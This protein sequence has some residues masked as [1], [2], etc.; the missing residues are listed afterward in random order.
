M[1]I[2]AS[3]PLSAGAAS[4]ARGRVGVPS[5]TARLWRPRIRPAIRQAHLWLGLGLGGLFALISLTGSALVFYVEIDRVL[6]PGIEQTIAS[7]APDWSSPVWDRALKTARARW[8][9]P[10]GRWSFEVTGEAGSIPARYYPSA[11]TSHHAVREMVWFSSDGAKVLR[12]EPWGSYLMSWLY[13]LHMHLLAGEVG[14]QVV[15]WSGVAALALMI[16]GLVVWWPRG[17]LRKA[18]AFKR[19]AAP[20]RRL[21]D[22][23]KLS[24]LWSFAFLIIL[25]GTGT[26]LA[27]PSVKTA[28]IGSMIAVPDTVPDPR[29][30]ASSGRQIP[31][32]RALAAAHEALPD[33]RL[34]YID[35]PGAGSEP[36]R[37]RMQVPGDPHR[38]FPGSFV[39]VDQYTGRVLAVH[40]VRRGNA[41]TTAAAWIRVLHD[42]S[43][44]GLPTRILTIILGL[45]PA[46]MFVTGILHWRRRLAARA[47]TL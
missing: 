29:S 11:H 27:L 44:G 8:H 25:A 34:A 42:G 2:S 14:R 40:D 46:F 39:F 6:N 41:G 17:S 23:H 5:G 7:A 35:V 30:V 45:I 9:D 20:T 21:R 18:V 36:F 3:R 37:L 19:R 24:G 32:T 15:G 47:H 28:L 26:L 10:V 16:S 1:N 43:V 31:V 4:P 38:R 33:A 13:E 22:L 12:A